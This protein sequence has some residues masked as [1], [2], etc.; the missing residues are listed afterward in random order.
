MNK[1]IIVALACVVLV[2]TAFALVTVTTTKQ[3]G[4]NAG[5]EEEAEKSGKKKSTSSASSEKEDAEALIGKTISQEK[6]K[7][8]LGE[9]EKF[10]MSSEGC[11]R[12]V[13]AGRFY[14]EDFTIFSK[15]Y[16]KGK[17]FRIVSVN[18]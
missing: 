15:T 18:E 17:T 13:Y 16:D 1:K 8:S 10:D 7:K 2:I 11:E 9:W 6:V 5:A 4:A 14:Y 12:G 3:S